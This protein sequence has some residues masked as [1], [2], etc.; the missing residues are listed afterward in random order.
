MPFGQSRGIV[1]VLDPINIVYMNVTPDLPV[2]FFG[3]QVLKPPL[4]PRVVEACDFTADAWNA[5]FFYEDSRHVFFVTTEEEQVRVYDYPHYG[6][7]ASSG[8]AVVADIPPLVWEEVET[9]GPKYWGDGGPVDTGW[10]VTNPDPARRFVTEDAYI[11]RGIGSAGSVRYGDQLIGPGGAIKDV[12]GMTG[13]G[14]NG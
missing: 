2:Q 10:G 14:F 13:G 5:P 11:V 1:S 8:D 7:A 9:P 3:R 12:K 4:T 6:V